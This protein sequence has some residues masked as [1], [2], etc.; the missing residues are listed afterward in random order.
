MGSKTETLD[1]L[2]ELFYIATYGCNRRLESV[3][4]NALQEQC[5]PNNFV[6]H[7]Y[8]FHQ[9]LC[10]NM[11][12]SEDGYILAPFAIR[13]IERSLLI[14]K[15]K[16]KG[17]RWTISYIPRE[18]NYCI[19]TKI[20]VLNGSSWLTRAAFIRWKKKEYEVTSDSL[21]NLQSKNSYNQQNN[22]AF[23]NETELD[24][25]YN[26]KSSNARNPHDKW[27]GMFSNFTPAIFRQVAKDTYKDSRK[28]PHD[29]TN[30]SRNLQYGFMKL[31]YPEKSK[32]TPFFSLF[33]PVASSH[34]FYGAVWF[35]FPVV[36]DNCREDMKDNF[37]NIGFTIAGAIN[38]IYVPTLALL[39]NHFCEKMANN[40]KLDGFSLSD[41]NGSDCLYNNVFFK[42]GSSDF[43]MDEFKGD[44]TLGALYDALK[45]DALPITGDSIT[46]LNQLLKETNL[47]EQIVKTKT[48]K[49]PSKDLKKLEETYTKS[50]AEYDLKRR[51]RLLL[52]EFYPN[53]TP[54]E[55]F[56]EPIE[57]G[58]MGLWENRQVMKGKLKYDD[59]TFIFRKY[60]V[61]SK[62][63]VDLTRKVI[64]D[65]EG[66]KVDGKI[67]PCALVIGSAG[68]GKDTFAKMSGIFSKSFCAGERHTL[69]MASLKPAPL[70]SGMVM[71][72]N[73][74][75]G[76]PAAGGAYNTYNLNL[77][78]I[79]QKIRQKTIKSVTAEVPPVNLDEY[80]KYP[81]LVLDE[82]NSM[83]ID[84]QGVLLRF[85][86]NAEM[87]PL[88]AIEDIGLKND[89]LEKLFPN[90]DN[91]RKLNSCLVIGVMNEDPDE[92]SR[93][94]AMDFINDRSY[95]GGLLG[96]F[97][98][99]HFAKMRRLRPDIK[100]RMS[101]NGKYKLPML[102]DRK[103]D[104]PLLFFIQCKT[105]LKALCGKNMSLHVTL[106]AFDRLMSDT[107]LW[108][109]N[110]RELQAL[111]K[112]V[113]A[114]A[115]K[116]GGSTNNCIITNRHV[117]QGLEDLYLIV[118]DIITGSAN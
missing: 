12:I 4:K 53:E 111:A 78:G 32:N 100:Y 75:I 92:L 97:L 65:A 104:I 83:D 40:S 38:D 44:Y 24:L 71:G 17:G 29:I 57:K 7:E 90:E 84:S 77:K 9:P 79:L 21:L 2:Y 47:Y 1:S 52:E 23:K 108:R 45:K 16:K 8:F 30:C 93:E 56:S 50:K 19:N 37:K 34:I 64:E 25:T 43:Y 102:K 42:L 58:L 80:N 87:I 35:K 39:H 18:D 31:L 98:Y 62:G 109:G 76:M 3:V 91:R 54:K 74:E 107:L 117:N 85:L 15:A 20:R 81:T 10:R 5:L 59:D 88:G 95:L 49:D 48:G 113:V 63:M 89:S 69:N 13:M 26:F 82:L 110:V 112:R 118:E 103:E 27:F 73:A 55:K 28:K 46:A 66:I 51:N 61:C 114:R 96:D 60:L 41:G 67:L 116:D 70:V 6:F 36:Y 105:E 86:E 106:E 115:L 94:K 33:V 68:S 72:V 14:P 101:R 99:E 11:N 22:I